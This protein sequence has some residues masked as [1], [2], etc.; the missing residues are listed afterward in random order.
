[1]YNKNSLKAEE[2]INDEEVLRTLDYAEKNKN[3]LSLINDILEKARPV[4]TGRETHCKGLTHEEASVLL[5]CD[6]KDV[7]KKIY[8]GFDEIQSICSLLIAQNIEFLLL[9]KDALPVSSLLMCSVD[10]R[11]SLSCQGT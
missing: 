4:K 10:L 11:R 6:D 1:M 3:N 9:Y 5:A 7:L 2:F 8:L